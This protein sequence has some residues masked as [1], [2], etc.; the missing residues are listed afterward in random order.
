MT[1]QGA[2]GKTRSLV[3]NDDL[4]FAQEL[5]RNAPLQLV[6]L[7][8]PACP[9]SCGACPYSWKCTASQLSVTVFFKE[10]MQITRIFLRQI[11]NSGVITVQFLKW[12]YPPMG[13]V[14]GNIGR[15]IW[16]VTD[17]TSM[18][19]SVLVLRIGPKKSGINLNVTAD[20]SQAELPSS[21]RK[22][23]TGGVL[24]T[25]ERPPNA[26]LNYGPFLE[27]V[28]FSGRVLYPSRTRS[29]YKN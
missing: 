21:L 24:I 13:V 2:R 7:T 3:W 9:D 22:T 17:D 4:D 15:T 8:K 1:G 26:G 29:Y 14:E 25:M 16:N 6:D 18:C 20:G 12:V 28:R 27:W 11:K 5:A 19:Q 10:P 23:A